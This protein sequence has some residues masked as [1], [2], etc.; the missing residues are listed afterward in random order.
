MRKISII[1]SHVFA[2]M[3][4]AALVIICLGYTMYIFPMIICALLSWIL[5][6]IGLSPEAIDYIQRQIQ[7][8][9]FELEWDGDNGFLEVKDHEIRCGAYTLYVDFTISESGVTDHG[10]YYTPP[11]FTSYG[12]EVDVNAISVVATGEEEEIYIAPR[13]AM[14]LMIEIEQKF[15]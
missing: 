10:D 14:Q 2:I 1:F 12:K 8:E 11:S 7:A 5:V 13:H 6:P 9:E 15:Q 4:L 3:A